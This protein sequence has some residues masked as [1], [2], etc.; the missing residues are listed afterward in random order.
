MKQS[1]NPRRRIFGVAAL[2]AV[3]AM[4]VVVAPSVGAPS[5]LTKQAAGK[6]YLTQKAARGVYLTQKTA[7]STYATNKV[8]KK[9]YLTK[10]QAGETYLRADRTPNEPVVQVNTRTTAFGPVSSTTALDVSGSF[11]SFK[12][13]ESGFVVLTLSGTSF[14]K[15]GTNNVACPVSLLID[16]AQ[17]GFGK[18]P[19]D[20]SSA[21]TKGSVKTLVS[22]GAVTAGPHVAS[23]QYAGSTDASVQWTLSN[24]NLTVQG[25]PGTTD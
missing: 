2:A 12:M 25:Y 24:F 11:T 1:N 23:I 6:V 13:P 14:C 18:A 9:D 3:L 4:A 20:L 17:T 15:A 8:L 19:L 7:K 21:A 10:A 22:T 16:G 5:F